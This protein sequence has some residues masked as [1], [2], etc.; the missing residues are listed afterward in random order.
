MF[1]PRICLPLYTATATCYATCTP[2]PAATT[3]ISPFL[4]SPA[5]GVSVL[6]VGNFLWVWVTTRTHLRSLPG[7][8]RILFIHHTRTLLRSAHTP[9]DT[10]MHSHYHR[11]CTPRATTCL[12]ALVL[13]LQFAPR[14]VLLCTCPTYN[15]TMPHTLPATAPAMPAPPTMYAFSAPTY[16]AG[17]SHRSARL[18][19]YCTCNTHY[20]PPLPPLPFCLLLPVTCFLV[21][22]LPVQGSIPRYYYTACYYTC[23]VQEVL[24]HH[25][26]ACRD[27][28]LRILY[29]W[30]YYVLTPFSLLPFYGYTTPPALQNI[31]PYYC[32]HHTAHWDSMDAIYLRTSLDDT[33]SGFCYRCSSAYVLQHITPPLP[34][35][36][37]VLL[38]Y[39]AGFLHTGFSVHCCCVLVAAFYAACMPAPACRFAAPHACV[40]H[41]A[42]ALF[43]FFCALPACST[44]VLPRALLVRHCC[45]GPHIPAAAISHT[46][47]TFSFAVQRIPV[48]VLPPPPALHIPAHTAL[49][50]LLCL[51]FSPRLPRS[52]PVFC[53]RCAAATPPRTFCTQFT[54]LYACHAHYLPA[55]F[56]ISR[57]T[58]THHHTCTD[59]CALHTA[60]M[61]YHLSPLLPVDCRL[62]LPAYLHVYSPNATLCPAAPPRYTCSCHHTAAGFTTR[63][64]FQIQIP[65]QDYSR[66]KIPFILYYIGIYS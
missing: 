22:I 23:H 28:L 37:F 40:L 8:L 63:R 48:L 41:F 21:L 65:F 52:V 44:Y 26:P 51:P 35:L 32:Y 42:T 2:S 49:F 13:P 27:F 17:L 24:H 54:C 31:L 3:I 59:M 5:H 46:L 50:Y 11:T 16:T 20:L 18:P 66:R 12:P 57:T 53:H 62:V 61:T 25:L 43:W 4:R 58:C 1:L 56:G 45:T 34:H 10:H 15:N 36:D 9:A 55:Y 30:I 47:R 6:F 19:H 64:I 14:F 7:T 29:A 33:F 38:D 39:F 60:R